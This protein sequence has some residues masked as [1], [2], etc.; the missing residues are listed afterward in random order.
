MTAPWLSTFSIFPRGTGLR[1]G[2]KIDISCPTQRERI[3]RRYKRMGFRLLALVVA[4]SA[5]SL[6]VTA[7]QVA[8]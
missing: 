7:A 2:I 6:A 3:I 1:Y 8:A 4:I 5:S